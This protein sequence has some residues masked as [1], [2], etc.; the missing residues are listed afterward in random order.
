MPVKVMNP[1]LYRSKGKSGVDVKDTCSNTNLV[2]IINVLLI[3]R[4]TDMAKLKGRKKISK[5]QLFFLDKVSKR[6]SI[7]RFLTNFF[8][9]SSGVLYILLSNPC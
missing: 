7:M 4:Q 3:L 2:L 8:T 5:L 9:G 1:F 6:L